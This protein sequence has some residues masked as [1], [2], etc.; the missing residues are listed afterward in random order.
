MVV[1]KLQ[2]NSK[3]PKFVNLTLDDENKYL[4]YKDVVV[5]FG[6]KK[7]DTISETKLADI[8]YQDEFYRAKDLA[9]K[10]FSYR[11]RTEFELKQKL[12]THKFN[13]K[14]V[15]AV[16]QNLKNIGLI[17]DQEYAE[18]FSNDTLKRK[19]VGKILLKQRL[20]QK[21]IHKEIVNQLIKKIY[22]DI[23]EKENA[24]QTARK[25]LKKYRDSGKKYDEKR[26]QTRLAS[27]L[28]RRGYS[29]EVISQVIRK[30]F[31]TQQNS[32]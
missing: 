20:L 26:N 28:S 27:F 10:Y 5:K 11:K 31:K 14:A 4:I 6:L 7:N 25:Q 15:D 12:S 16:M 13:L 2:I 18:S 21:G 3:K 9:L 24:F 19:S 32:E 23:D 1:T 22:K 30:L 17:N 8:L 29:W